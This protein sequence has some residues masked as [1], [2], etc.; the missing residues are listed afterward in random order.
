MSDPYAS[1][2]ALLLHCDGTNGSTAFPDSSLVNNIMTAGGNA[3]VSTAA[4]EFGTGSY[5]AGSGFGNG[6]TTPMITNGPLDLNNGGDFTVE[7]WVNSLSTNS[8][9]QGIIGSCV[10]GVSG[11]YVYFVNPAA[12]ITAQVFIGGSGFSTSSNVVTKDV[13]NHFAFVRSGTT[14]TMYV[15]GVAGPSTFTQAG[16][17]GAPNTNM[18]I[19]SITGI[20]SISCDNIDELRITKGVA[21]YTS[22]FTPPTA[23]FDNTGNPDGA[24]VYGKFLTSGQGFAPIQ[25][26]NLGNAKPR[27]WQPQENLT[28]KVLR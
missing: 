2:V 26:A 28:I 21:R 19:G 4:P 15:N 6:L 13:W 3:N 7:G 10:S 9:T 24:P 22:N 27:L 8:F 25:S 16:A 18:S 23:P 20:T 14:Y 17:L 5:S 11:W 12:T 1:N